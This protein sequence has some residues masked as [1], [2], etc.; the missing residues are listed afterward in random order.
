M[1]SPLIDLVTTQLRDFIA[2]AQ[3]RGGG[4]LPPEI[5]LAREFGVSRPVLRHALEA[6]RQEGLVESRRGSGNFVRPPRATDAQVFRH[7]QG[8]DDLASC[9]DFRAVIESA[10]AF[11]A[12]RHPRADLVQA[13]ESACRQMEESAMQEGSVFEADFAFHLA[14]ARAS[15]NHYFAATLEFLRHPI[16]TAYLLGRQLRNVPLN[17]TSTRV[18]TEHRQIL[19]AIQGGDPQAAQL[20]MFEHIRA[21][22]NRLF[23]RDDL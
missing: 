18:A 12:A 11:E 10:A 1:P 19:K 8:L 5:K 14:V 23:G 7:P 17:V 16:E 22:R 2:Q 4:K 15:G 13:I 21:G 3:W 6:L 20:R 9:F